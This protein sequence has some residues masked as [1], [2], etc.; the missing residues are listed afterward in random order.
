MA[1]TLMRYYQNYDLI[2]N[3]TGLPISRSP[4]FSVLLWVKAQNSSSANND[5]RAFAEGSSAAVN[6]M[7]GVGTQQFGTNGATRIYFRDN[8]GTV[9]VDRTS[10]NRVAP[11]D[12][13]WHHLAW[14]A[15]NGVATLY[16]DG[17]LDSTNAYTPGAMPVDLTTLGCLLRTTTASF[18][19]GLVDDVA[20]WDR[21]LS[22]DEVQQ[23]LS[24]SIAL[25]VPPLP[26]AV[27]VQPAGSTNLWPSDAW[28]FSGRAGGIRPLTY[29]WYRM[30]RL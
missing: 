12:N 5:R 16:I 10:T 15:N 8:G 7:L 18:Y 21:A 4:V 25:P 6:P 9:R 30:E 22:Q 1:Q 11:F 3:D 27:T 29:Q 14:V 23:V 19:K 26:P 17:V 24:N 13:A 20:V 28:T 2:N